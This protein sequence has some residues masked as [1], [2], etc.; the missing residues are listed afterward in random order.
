MVRATALARRRR[1]CGT[2]EGSRPDP[3]RQWR[4]KSP[5]WRARQR[6]APQSTGTPSRGASASRARTSVAS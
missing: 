2:S 6:T 5:K 3:A 4:C 1:G